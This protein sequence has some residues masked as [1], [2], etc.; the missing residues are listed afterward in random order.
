M[1]MPP[2]VVQRCT[3]H[4]IS[5]ISG[6]HHNSS[7]IITSSHISYLSAFHNFHFRSFGLLGGAVE[8]QPHQRG[9][10]ATGADGGGDGHLR[11][12]AEAEGNQATLLGEAERRWQRWEEW[13]RQRKRKRK[14]W[15][16][17]DY[18]N[19]R[20]LTKTNY[21]CIIFFGVLVEYVICFTTTITKAEEAKERAT[22]AVAV[23]AV[24]EHDLSR[25]K[26]RVCVAVNYSW[27]ACAK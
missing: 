21:Y 14:G 6:Y 10:R 25:S 12:L 2:T 22:K 13:Q 1:S 24:A 15:R 18:K 20:L 19:Q 16:F 27:R 3:A 17:H 9:S 8:G 4:K 23:D 26:P 11:G 5:Q 7:H